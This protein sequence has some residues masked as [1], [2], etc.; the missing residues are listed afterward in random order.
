MPIIN[1][2][3]ATLIR[4]D[5]GRNGGETASMLTQTIHYSP[6]VCKNLNQILRLMLP[7]EKNISVSSVSLV[8]IFFLCTY[9]VKTVETKK[10]QFNFKLFFCSDHT[11]YIFKGAMIFFSISIG[12]EI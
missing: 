6:L 1:N 7:T 5:K 10:N 9:S 11:P 4:L 3:S 12:A 8:S 2:L